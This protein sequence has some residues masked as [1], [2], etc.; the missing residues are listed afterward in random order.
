MDTVVAIVVDVVCP[1][2]LECSRAAMQHLV[3]D[4]QVACIDC[5]QG[6]EDTTTSDNS[7]VQNVSVV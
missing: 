7:T 6:V 3:V 5:Q 2:G 4:G 1:T